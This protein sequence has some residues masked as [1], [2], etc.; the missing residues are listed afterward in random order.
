MSVKNKNRVVET[1]TAVIEEPATIPTTNLATAD[2]KEIE[3]LKAEGKALDALNALLESSNKQNKVRVFTVWLNKDLADL[4]L[5]FN[6]KNPIVANRPI[7][8]GTVESMSRQILNGHFR[9]TGEP[10][11]F[12]DTGDGID[13]QH[14]CYAVV[15]AAET[16][17]NAGFETTVVTGIHVDN[18]ESLIDNLLVMGV[19]KRTKMNLAHFANVDAKKWEM[20]EYYLLPEDIRPGGIT[21][22]LSKLEINDAYKAKRQYYD[23][24]YTKLV[25]MFTDHEDVNEE[26]GEKRLPLYAAVFLKMNDI[27]PEAAFKFM[28]AFFNPLENDLPK[29]NAVDAIRQE[30]VNAFAVG[31]RDLT[32]PIFI[33]RGMLAAFKEFVDGNVKTKWHSFIATTMPAQPKPEPKQRRTKNTE[34]AA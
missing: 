30:L 17:P 33:R 31:Q 8:W 18:M 10:L 13:L 21:R 15:K 29:G 1:G 3:A 4:L 6:L 28:S 2:E 22:A 5:K 32:R 20:V 26:L 24:S 16:N 14:R 23:D 7:N 12:T 9:N 19:A 11:L 27:N 34:V 25:T